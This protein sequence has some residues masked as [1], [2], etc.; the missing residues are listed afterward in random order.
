MEVI[1]LN[2]TFK[3]PLLGLFHSKKNGCVINKK[4]EDYNLTTILIKG[5]LEKVR[6]SKS[7]KTTT[8]GLRMLQN[9]LES[10]PFGHGQKYI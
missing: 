9:D 1:I 2:F 7:V 10:K 4:R 6:K 3:E 5:H 8:T